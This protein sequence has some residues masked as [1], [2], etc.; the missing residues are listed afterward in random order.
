LA[1]ELERMKL[2]TIVEK[3][4]KPIL[5]TV[6]PLA[7]AMLAYDTGCATGYQDDSLINVSNSNGG[8]GGTGGS[9]NE[10]G[11][12]G[13]ALLCAPHAKVDC[14]QGDVYWNNSCNELEELYQDCTP[15]QK[16]ENGACIEKENC[17]ANIDVL[18]GCQEIG[19][20]FNDDY[21]NKTCLWN[22]I[23]G[24]PSVVDEK[25][26]VTGTALLH[27]K[28][29]VTISSC[30]NDFTVKYAVKPNT[31]DIPGSYFISLR[32]A[33]PASTGVTFTHMF[34]QNNKIILG[35]NGFQET[36]G[37]FDLKNINTIEV[38]KK[39]VK[40][41][42]YVDKVLSGSYNCINVTQIPIPSMYL[43]LGSAVMTQNFALDKVTVYCQ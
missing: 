42:L 33:S 32:D 37:D 13:E 41:E 19:C 9:I 30:N 14:F 3:S 40:F 24:L 38:S 26:Q 25:L 8:N 1:L 4:G 31:P 34:G 39:G 20:Q 2:E 18:A 7:T 15:T 11:K 43:E 6:L 5:F 28:N 23:T 36:F 27:T 29:D 21:K 12:G 22:T 17:P 10:G 35:C 16:C